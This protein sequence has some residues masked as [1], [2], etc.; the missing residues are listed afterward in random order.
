MH[1]HFA[2]RNRSE[3]NRYS[4]GRGFTLIELLVVIAI[5]AILAGLLL[6]A[7][8]KAKSKGK[9]IVSLSNVKQF[10]YAFYMYTED[11]D[12]YFP[13]EGNGFVPLDDPA[14]A[15]AWY[16]STAT[17]TGQQTLLAMHQQG[18]PPSLGARSIFVCP[19]GT[20]KGVSTIA[21]PIFWY[22]FNN[23]MD[24]NGPAQFKRSQCLYPVDTVTFTEGQEN[25]FPSTSGR[26]ADSFVRHDRRA[27]LGFADGHA[28]PISFADCFR[29]TSEDSSPAEFSKPR[30][31]YWWPYPGAQP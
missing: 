9:A 27:N 3:S 17:Y 5:I 30:K 24:P 11:F 28:A 1:K 6:P 29:N 18:S 21:K 16:N 22:G 2:S 25:E 31:V 19:S 4:V 10:G 7:L 26:F 13:E 8:A 14:N 12:D 20:N 23:R 15:N